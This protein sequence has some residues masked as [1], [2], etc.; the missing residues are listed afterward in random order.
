[1]AIQ[2]NDDINRL[3]RDCTG[4]TCVTNETISHQHGVGRDHAPWLEHEKGAQGLAALHGLFT[5]FDPQGRL[6]P[7]CLLED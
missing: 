5:H 2:N 7:G 6:N 4:F 3:D 1:M